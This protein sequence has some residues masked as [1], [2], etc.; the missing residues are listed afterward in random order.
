MNI[1]EN[2]GKT[3]SISLKISRRI[4]E[5][6]LKSLWQSSFM[7]TVCS[8]SYGVSTGIYFRYLY[9]LQ[10]KSLIIEEVL[11]CRDDVAFKL[12]ALAIQG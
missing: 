4:R 6:F 1:R 2:Q 5:F 11:K 12:A 9:Y 3:E 7:L 8:C 10:L